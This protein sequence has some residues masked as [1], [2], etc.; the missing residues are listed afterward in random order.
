MPGNFFCNR[1]GKLYRSHAKETGAEPIDQKTQ[2]F[3][4]NQYIVLLQLDLMIT[5]SCNTKGF[6]KKSYARSRSRD[7]ILSDW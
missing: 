4:T 5:S 2:F 1:I 6:K 7:C 3:L